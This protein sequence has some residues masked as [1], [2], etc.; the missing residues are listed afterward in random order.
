LNLHT[1]ARNP[2]LPARLLHHIPTPVAGRSHCDG[3]TINESATQPINVP[4]LRRLECS[5]CLRQ[6][7]VWCRNRTDL[8]RTHYRKSRSPDF[9]HIPTPA[10]IGR[11]NVS[12]QSYRL[13]RLECSDCLR[14]S[15]VWRPRSPNPSPHSNTPSLDLTES[16]STGGLGCTYDVLKCSGILTGM[17]ARFGLSRW[18]F[19]IGK[20]TCS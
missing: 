17:P 9:D 7:I 12:L 4:S 1:R 14:Q 11:S 16:P 6:S 13:W 19:H 10:S 20:I 3:I 18:K 8:R 2:V 15:V 5:D